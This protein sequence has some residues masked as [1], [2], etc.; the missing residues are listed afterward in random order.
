MPTLQEHE[1]E[2]TDHPLSG[3]HVQEKLIM[4][5]AGVRWSAVR[6]DRFNPKTTLCGKRIYM[7]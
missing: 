1:S 2:T 7:L 4:T 5:V 6:G 3:G